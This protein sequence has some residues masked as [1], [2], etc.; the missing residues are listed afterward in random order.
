[1]WRLKTVR[2]LREGHRNPGG[3]P[4]D[5]STACPATEHETHELPDCTLN[6]EEFVERIETRTRG[7]RVAGVQNS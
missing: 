7:C 6:A 5:T 3:V 1:M 4:S 2:E